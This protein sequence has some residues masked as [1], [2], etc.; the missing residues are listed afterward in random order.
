V[1]SEEEKCDEVKDNS[2]LVDVLASITSSYKLTYKEIKD[3][4]EW[5]REPF[6]GYTKEDV[7]EFLRI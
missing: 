3:S 5:E 2:V 6:S 1:I 7:K 4:I